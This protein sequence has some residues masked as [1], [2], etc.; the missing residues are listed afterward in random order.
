MSF[1]DPD[2]DNRSGAAAAAVSEQDRKSRKML[3][4]EKQDD[5]KKYA[6]EPNVVEK[7]QNMENYNK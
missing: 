1:S 3:L 4:D 5:G 6:S 7:V 2:S